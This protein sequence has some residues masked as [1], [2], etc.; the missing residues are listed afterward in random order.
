MIDKQRL[1]HQTWLTHRLS[2]L[3]DDPHQRLLRTF[4]TWHQ[5]PQLRAKAAVKPLTSGSRRVAGE[6]FHTAR[7][8]LTW[9]DTT[10][11]SLTFCE[12][13]DL[14]AWHALIQDLNDTLGELLLAGRTPAARRPHA[15]RTPAVEIGH[16][17]AAYTE[18]IERVLGVP[19]GSVTLID[20]TT[21]HDWLAKE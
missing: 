19:A 11:R 16:T 12:Q 17:V 15:G 21:L 2:E 4:A 9:L 18:A 10:G 1:H 7:I 6:Q 20:A 14:D 3:H 8:F 13:A 5:L